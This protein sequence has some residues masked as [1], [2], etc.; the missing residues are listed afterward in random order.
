MGRLTSA[1]RSAVATALR[2]LSSFSPSSMRGRVRRRG[3]RIGR[4][5][6]NEVL[7]RAV[8]IEADFLRVGADERPREDAAGE[9]RQIASLER[10]ERHHGNARAV[11]DLPQ[12][13]APLLTRFT[14]ASAN[15]SGWGTLGHQM[16]CPPSREALR[17][18]SPQPWRRRTLNVRKPPRMCQ[19]PGAARRRWFADGDR[20]TSLPAARTGRCRRCRRPR[21]EPSRPPARQ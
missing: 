1:S 11:R 4:Q 8:G 15:C 10:L 14:E 7:D 3:C 19:T 2:S 6:G 9:S 18:V 13:D 16:L 5:L 17:R 21:H 12:R 20:P